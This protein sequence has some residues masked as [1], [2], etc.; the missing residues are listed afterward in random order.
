MINDVQPNTND[1]GVY[2]I[3]F[4][5]SLAFG[6][7]ASDLLYENSKM[8]TQLL[9]CINSSVLAEFPCK[10]EFRKKSYYTGPHNPNTMYLQDPYQKTI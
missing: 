8:R 6:R 9:N 5:V 10:P 2:T 3:A 1:S 7:E 4:A